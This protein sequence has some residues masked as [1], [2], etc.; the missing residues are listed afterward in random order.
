M[1]ERVLVLN[2]NYEVLNYVNWKKAL[3]LVVTDQ[4][5]IVHESER[6]VRTVYLEFMVPSVIRLIHSA[7]RPKSGAKF[8]RVNVLKRD[9]YTCQYCGKI[10]SRHNLTID[11]VI[12]KSLG[13]RTKW[14][15]VVAACK[16]CNNKKD[17][18]LPEQAGMRLIRKPE[19]PL[20]V[21]TIVPINTVRPEWV[22]YL[23]YAP[24]FQ[25]VGVAE[26]Q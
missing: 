13:G 25:I 12:P 4:A 3:C 17:D 11:H 6:I 19:E 26:D 15:N 7:V 21:R 10:F 9:R 18:R 8:S 14:E 23:K 1:S 16:R 22:D 5:E 24:G 2:R 20:Y